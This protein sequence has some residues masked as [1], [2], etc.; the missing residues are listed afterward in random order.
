MNYSEW[1]EFTFGSDGRHPQIFRAIPDDS[2]REQLQHCLTFFSS[3]LDVLKGVE[4]EVTRRVLEIFPG[5]DGYGGLLAT[6]KLPHSERAQFAR[7][8]IGFFRQV[9]FEDDFDGAGFLWW[10]RLV[11]AAWQDDP[12]VMDDRRICDEVM[13][14]IE[15][16][17]FLG[18][19]VCARSALHGVVEIGPF[20]TPGRSEVVLDHF[21]QSSL[22]SDPGLLAYAQEVASGNAQ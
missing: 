17:L 14:A 1:I 6:C 3:P 20:A 9:F 21:F 11:G 18:S 4:Q 7:A 5:I 8:H 2:A 22:T 13:V 12:R 16:I 19:K 15:E 10:E